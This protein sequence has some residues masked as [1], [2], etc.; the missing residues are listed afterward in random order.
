MHTHPAPL[1]APP[2]S[3]Q[4]D[5]LAA[6]DVV[7]AS[8]TVLMRELRAVQQ[9]FQSHRERR[10]A[11]GLRVR[12]ADE[13]SRPSPL[14][15]LRFWRVLLDEVQKA[16]GSYA[17]GKTVR[18]VSCVHRWAVSGTPMEH[19]RLA[20]LCEL[21][22]FVKG[23]GSEQHAACVEAAARL[24]VV[25]GKAGRDGEGVPKGEGEERHAKDEVEGERGRE[26]EGVWKGEGMRKGEEEE[27]HAVGEEA[28]GSER[29]REGVRKGEGEERVGE[30][31]WKGEAHVKG[32]VEGTRGGDREEEELAAVLR[33]FFLRRTKSLLRLQIPPQRIVVCPFSLSLSE[34][35]LHTLF[36]LPSSLQHA[37]EGRDR[38]V[39]TLLVDHVKRSLLSPSL[40]SQW[41]LKSKRSVEMA[42]SKR[43]DRTK[44]TPSAL[45]GELVDD[46]SPSSPR[47][48]LHKPTAAGLPLWPPLLC[49]AR[50]EVE[51]SM[52][53]LREL[54]ETHAF[55]RGEVQLHDLQ[56][57]QLLAT[58]RAVG[59]LGYCGSPVIVCGAERGGGSSGVGEM[60][61]E[62]GG[63]DEMDVGS[64]GKEATDGEGERDKDEEER[65]VVKIKELRGMRAGLSQGVARAWG[66]IRCSLHANER[67]ARVEI[68][69]RRQ[70]TSH[71][72][73]VVL[74]TLTMEGGEA[75][76]WAHDDSN[77]D[78]VGAIFTTFLNLFF[79]PDRLASGPRSV[80]AN[81]RPVEPVSD[82]SRWAE[83]ARLLMLRMTMQQIAAEE[84][85]RFS[86][87]ITELWRVSDHGIRL[88]AY[89]LG[90]SAVRLLFSLSSALVDNYRANDAVREGLERMIAPKSRDLRL[91]SRYVYILL[92]EKP[93]GQPTSDEIKMDLRRLRHWY[94]AAANRKTCR[95]GLPSSLEGLVARQRILREEKREVLR[96]ERRGREDREEEQRETAARA[97]D[98][99]RDRLLRLQAMS[100]LEASTREGWECPAYGSSKLTALVHL[101]LNDIPLGEK[102]VVFT[103]FSDALPLVT[104]V[105]HAASIGA[106]S[107]KREVCPPLWKAPKSAVDVFRSDP[108]CRVLLLEAGQSAAGLTLTCAAHVV[109]L[110][111][112]NSTQLEEQAAAR[113]A[114]IGQTK[115][116]T[117][118]HLIARD[119]ADVLLR[120]IADSKRSLD[121][122]NGRPESIVGVLQRAAEL[123]GKALERR[124]AALERLKGRADINNDTTYD[125]DE[126]LHTEEN[127]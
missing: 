83:V 84:L 123:S 70:L 6:C 20:D 77:S 81:S 75:H 78:E 55:A 71:A 80:A 44:G 106:I 89:P 28:G 108:S 22:E 7:L 59:A 90:G 46:R 95:G 23:R 97:L 93:P 50:A 1:A 86:H 117:V 37:A 8:Y 33:P 72:M 69:R 17:A 101:L 127:Q 29:E 42:T 105:L 61:G 60:K 47:P 91:H 103:R 18:L 112:L 65:R 63:C 107:L 124:V 4:V 21:V 120:Q 35:S 9:S 30:S 16:P 119:S 125:H 40:W 24:A 114:R 26:G 14:K 25:E 41:G 104:R 11:L 122:G 38:Q 85:D 53:A 96:Q 73:D 19:S 10:A 82:R 58:I 15:Y 2:A 126:R 74:R 27:R 66:G 3:S 45:V 68:A 51:K 34:L 54:V 109:F 110:D 64:E 43:C 121:V 12:E 115:R 87:G 13:H 102:A 76:A 99:V 113:V 32:Q 111:V 100:E 36:V 39:A 48:L 57:L 56:V 31:S 98:S 79:N 49:A 118:W 88:L 116:T 52:A 62:E 92:G 94:E 5:R 67:H